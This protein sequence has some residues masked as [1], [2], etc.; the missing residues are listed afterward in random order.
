MY[1]TPSAPTAPVRWQVSAA[2][3]NSAIGSH[4]SARIRSMPPPVTGKP[5]CAFDGTTATDLTPKKASLAEGMV[6]SVAPCQ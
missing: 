1:F 4:V 2:A 3:F 6:R 5:R